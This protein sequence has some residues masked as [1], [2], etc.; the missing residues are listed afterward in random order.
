VNS[1]TSKGKV[2]KIT[3]FASNNNTQYEYNN[4]GLLQN[5][6]ETVDNIAH[7]TNY[8]Y[9]VFGDVLTTTYPSGLLI[10]NGYTSNGYLNTISGAGAT[11]YTTTS[12]NGQGQVIGYNKEKLVHWRGRIL[13]FPTLMAM[14]QLTQR[15]QFRII[16][17]LGI[18]KKAT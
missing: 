6:T 17:L 13:P 2:K 11:L 10:T 1:G 5:V 8:T 12:M 15:R 14:Q 4:R 3:G 7:V 16:S 18:I 9:N